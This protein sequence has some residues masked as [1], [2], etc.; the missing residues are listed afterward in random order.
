MQYETKSGDKDLDTEA[1]IIIGPDRVLS[2]LL[3]IFL[4]CIDNSHDT[5]FI[6]KMALETASSTRHDDKNHTHLC[7]FKSN[8]AHYEFATIGTSY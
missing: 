4:C 6:K 2:K 7:E 1:K 8:G 5:L 3:I